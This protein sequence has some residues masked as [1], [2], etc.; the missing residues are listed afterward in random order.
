MLHFIVVVGDGL[1]GRDF[2]VMSAKQVF[3]L[4]CFVLFQNV[5]NCYDCKSSFILSCFNLFRIFA[6]YFPFLK[7]SPFVFMVIFGYK[8]LL[9]FRILKCINASYNKIRRIFSFICILFK[10]YMHTCALFYCIKSTNCLK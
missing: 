2:R 5:A 1:R 10:M 3:I 8:K 6:L 4:Q 7:S 9:S